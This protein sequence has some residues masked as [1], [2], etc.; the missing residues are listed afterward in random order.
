MTRDRPSRSR[1]LYAAL[2][3]ATGL[4]LVVSLVG[5]PVARI[6]GSLRYRATECTVESSR[7]RIG[8][9]GGDESVDVEYR[10][11]VAGQSYTGTRYD[12]WSNKKGDGRE[13]IAAVPPGS[14]VPCFYDPE[15]PERAVIDRRIDPI[16]LLGLFALLPLGV[17]VVLLRGTWRARHWSRREFERQVEL[18]GV[19]PRRLALRRL[20]AAIASRLALYG[21]L[22]PALFMLCLHDRWGILGQ[23][24]RAEVSF[25]PGVWI[26]LLL[27]CAVT[28]SALFAHTVMRALGPRFA[29]AT[30]QPA[31]RGQ[32]VVLQWRAGGVTPSIRSLSLQLVAREEADYERPAGDA[33]ESGTE[34]REF[35]RRQV[36]RFAR[37]DRRTLSHGSVMVEL[38]AFAFSFDGGYNRIRWVV[39]LDADVA[40]W[41]DVSEELELDIAP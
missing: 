41:A 31:R 21:L 8:S 32:P 1:Y 18:I 13:I 14:R 16:R 7:L 30:V 4:V 5:L 33:T 2:L 29:L 19:R 38:P 25:L 10:Y 35:F 27:A 3:I 11:R 26:V 24:A 23:L 40:G 28:A 34:R 36:A 17:G 39:A 37:A 22:G 15:R 9:D 12:L 20:G 6:V